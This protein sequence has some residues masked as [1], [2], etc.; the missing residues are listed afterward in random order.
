MIIARVAVDLLLEAAQRTKGLDA[1]VAQ[2][3]LPLGDVAGVI[4]HGVGHIVAGHRGGGQDR[5]RAGAIKVD[6]L[7]VTRGELAVEIAGI[8]AVRGDLFH[9]D[10]DLLHGICKAGHIAQQH[11]HALALKS[12]LFGHGQADIRHEQTLH[13]RVGG[14]VHEHDRTREGAALLERVA[15]VEVV[16]VLEP[17]AA[18]HDHIHLGLQCDTGQE[19]VVRFTGAGKDRQLLRFDQRIEDIDHRDTGT[20]HVARD[21]ALGRVDRGTADIDQVVGQLGAAVARVGGAGEDT[22]QQCFGEGH[23]HGVTQKAHLGICGHAAC[24][25]EDLQGDFV[26]LQ[27]DHLGQRG[28]VARG[29]LG[30]LAVAHAFGAN[31]NDVTGN[32]VNA[33]VNLMH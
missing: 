3:E 29:D 14:G 4:R 23:L 1:A 13:D 20:H 7:L 8:A 11:Q 16:V 21:N 22:A 25:G 24:P 15:E 31:V 6:R 17:H 30:Q 19:W 28:A 12:E 5:D 10:G 32:V 26:V 9:R 18:Q 2:V 33:M 27:P